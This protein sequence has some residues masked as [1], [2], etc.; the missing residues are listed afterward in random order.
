MSSEVIIMEKI[1]SGRRFLA[2]TCILSSYIPT[3]KEKKIPGKV[4]GTDARLTNQSVPYK[5]Y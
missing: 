1:E 3:Q 2:T 5:I 4:H